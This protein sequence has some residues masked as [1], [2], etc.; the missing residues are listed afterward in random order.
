MHKMKKT[1]LSKS[2]KTAIGLSA[3]AFVFPQT[4][5]AQDS[6]GGAGELEEVL[7]TGSLIRNPNLTRS[8]PVNV[9]SSEEIEYQQINVIE[10]MLR[11]VPGAVPSI[12]ANVNNGNGG[13]SYVN[14]RGLGSN[15][16]VVLV[17]GRRMAPSELNGRFDL[18]NIPVALLERVDV[19]TGGASTTYGADAIA[20]VVNFITKTD[21]TGVEI[22][23][24]LG[25][26]AEGDGDKKSIE[27]TLGAD[28]DGGRGNA[29]FSIGYQ[30]SDPVYQGDRKFSEYVHFYDDGARGGS[31]LGSFNTRI[32]NVNP[33]GADNANLALGGVQDDRTFA[34]A[35]TPY[36]YG[37]SNV[38]QTPFER[39]NM[40]SSINYDI[41]DTVE[42]YAK[43]LY[44][45]N[46]VNTLI[47]PSGSF[48]DSVTIA[49]NHPFLSDAQRNALCA[50][51]TDSAA[52]TYTPQFT[53]AQCSAAGAATGP[54]DPNYLTVDT[55]LRRRNVEGGPRI[56]DY[57][58]HYFNYSLG[59][60]GDF[61]DSISWDVFGSYGRSDQTQTQKGYWLKS[62][63]R[64][65]LLSGPNGC[66]DSSSGCVPVDFFGPTGSIT[67]EMNNYLS[68]GESRI[69]MK[70]DMTQFSAN[71]SGEAGFSSPWANDEVNFALGFEFRDYKG[72]RES[73]LLSQSG[74]LGG[75]GGASPNIT[76]G[77]SVKELIAEAVIPIVQD[78]AF[79]EEVTAEVGV[80]YSDYTI[81]AN[82]ADG[83]SDTTWKL[84]LS[85]TPVEDVIARATFARAVRAP[86]IQELFEPVVTE[87]ENL[88]TDPCASVNDQGVNSGFVPT[89]A[90]RDVCIAQGAPAGAIGN[91]PQPAAGQV[92]VTGG[93]NLN[94]EPEESDSLTVGFVIQPSSI[95][96]LTV[97]V[98][99]YNITIDGAITDPTTG[100]AIAACFDN[101]DPTSSAC[102]SIVRSPINGGLSG[103]E[104]VV[105]G[106]P[107][108]LSNAGELETAGIDLAVNYQQAFGDFLWRT[109]F[110]ANKTTKSTFKASPT[111]INRDCV[112]LYSAD[113]ES[114]Q[115]E[116]TFNW[117]NTLSYEDFDVSLM[118]RYISSNEY[119]YAD[120]DT[121]FIGSPEGGVLGSQNFNKTESY[122]IFDLTMRYSITEN[123]AITGVVSNLLDEEPP[124]T[125]AF[126]GATGYNSGNTYPS[127]FD[128]VGRRYNLSAKLRF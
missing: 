34:A 96:D 103:D 13:F 127:T 14:L 93:G 5:L 109:S 117:R 95:P 75:A 91:I 35:F 106:L 8:A 49:L 54:T 23:T 63:F 53:P 66:N 6:E 76:G 50:F 58:G 60:R 89:G 22:N 67:D 33:T 36:N 128:A 102:T 32:G 41:T 104:A 9:I 108:A 45:T 70:F 90:L 118:W 38:F 31:G 124:L 114:I 37:P 7:V 57:T 83:F 123:F 116:K 30:N 56:S 46:T 100:D 122:S 71:V 2:I 68:G 51:D 92:N 59:L 61:N 43:A 47:A 99:Y 80:R 52:G 40:Y 18:N 26:T 115:P 21:F 88:A 39:Y 17:D 1:L 113:C 105:K 111:S 86:N 3:A 87:L 84:G 78:A 11:E 125:G 120:T 72:T 44:S 16:N 25:Q 27:V 64:S 101:P 29:V 110:V 12:G 24:S 4:V 42:I 97:T 85:W 79:A 62:R 10:E 112:G 107:L 119:E 20:G 65:S 48:G 126:I 77:Y 15:R 55:E 94:L 81:R 74:D 98:D 73:D 69:S 28:L 19:L 121:A 82:G